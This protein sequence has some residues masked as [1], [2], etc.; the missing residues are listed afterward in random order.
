MSAATFGEKVKFSPN[1]PLKFE[2]FEL[3]HTGE[4]RVVSDKFP[5]GF[6][7]HDFK[8]KTAA[9]EQ[10]VSWSSGTGDIAP[11]VFVIGGKKYELEL[12]ISDR[13]GKRACC[14]EKITRPGET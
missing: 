5:R 6:L 11:S 2:D 8:I 9:E 4:R 10:T 13:L 12:V 3:T 14:L 1:S 7:Y